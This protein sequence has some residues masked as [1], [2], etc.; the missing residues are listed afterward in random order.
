MSGRGGAGEQL[1]QAN[2]QGEK[3]GQSVASGQVRA[4]GVFVG[5]GGVS[6]KGEAAEQLCQANIHKYGKRGGRPFRQ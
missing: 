3:G 4:L 5:G 1:C 2:I 6:G